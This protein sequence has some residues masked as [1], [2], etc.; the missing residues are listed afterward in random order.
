[1]ETITGIKVAIEQLKKYESHYDCISDLIAKGYKYLRWNNEPT[2]WA[3]E[4]VQVQ[5]V[6]R[7]ETGSVEIHADPTRKLFY[8][9]DMSD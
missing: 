5:V 1:M 8:S 9:V 4:D 6:F 7:N 3:P 2:F